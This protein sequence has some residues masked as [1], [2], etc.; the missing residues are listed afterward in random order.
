M[1]TPFETLVERARARMPELGVPGVAIAVLHQGQVESI[2]LGVTSVENPLPM[3]ADTILQVGSIS[4]TF[5]GTTAMRLVDAGVL[6]LDAPVRSYLPELKLRDPSV[7]ASVTMRHLLSH[8]GGWA[9]DYFNDFGWGDDAIVRMVAA[10]AELEQ[11]TP[12][13]TVWHYNNAGFSI[14]ARVIEVVSGKA[15]ED[16]VR[17]LVFTPLGLS[18]TTFW[19]WEAMLKRFGVGHMAGFGNPPEPRVAS[20]WPIGRAT[21]GAGGIN[22]TVNDLIR[23]ARLHLLQLES[24]Q[25]MAL[26]AERV[27]EMQQPVTVAGGVADAWGLSWSIRYV[28]GRAV[29]GHGGA[30]NGFIAD[31]TMLPDAG[32][33]IAILTNCNRGREITGD[34]AS[35]AL[36][37]YFGLEKPPAPK[38]ELNSEQL[39]AYANHYDAQLQFIEL[40]VVDGRL[41]FQAIPKGHFPF[42]DSPP[43]PAPP[44]TWLSFITPDR[45]EMADGPG[46]GGIVEFLRNPDGSIAWLRTGGRLHRPLA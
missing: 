41:V 29:I 8:T 6:N 18:N 22:S 13:G 24:G 35:L 23:Y 5:L 14:A 46:K 27:R 36:K 43:A 37:S 1:P 30:T 40:K 31:L 9:G 44:P 33:A 34:V 42:P 21:H 26:S 32:F 3:T 38:I 12:V 19:P 4:K 10:C 2:G 11:L 45:A 16:A 20:P 39:A 25:A 28:Q 17:D 15:F 7:L